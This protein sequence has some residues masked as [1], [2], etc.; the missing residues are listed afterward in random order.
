M[1]CAVRPQWDCVSCQ[2]P[3]PCPP[4][5]VLLSEEY[6]SHR[7]ALLVFLAGCMVDAI[8]D[9]YTGSG[10]APTDLFDRMLGWARVL[11]EP[12]QLSAVTDD[13]IRAGHA[14]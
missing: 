7:S 12:R 3:W 4:A 10:P 6:S 2:E 13:A 11:T 1:H 9:S 5:K 14:A 8:N